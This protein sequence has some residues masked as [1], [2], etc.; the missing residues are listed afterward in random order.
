MKDKHSI[1]FST[2]EPILFNSNHERIDVNKLIETCMKDPKR[3]L[4]DDEI[5]VVVYVGDMGI[6]RVSAFGDPTTGQPPPDPN[7]HWGQQVIQIS[8]VRFPARIIRH[9]IGSVVMSITADS[10]FLI[11]E[12]YIRKIRAEDLEKGMVLH[13][14][15]KVYW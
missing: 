12:K 8:R 1:S 4:V 15:E 5:G 6:Y 9:Q 11:R 2:E 14:G 13:T 10:V 7:G 3:I